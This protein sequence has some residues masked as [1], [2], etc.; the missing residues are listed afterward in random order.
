[1]DASGGVDTMNGVCFSSSGGTDGSGGSGGTGGSGSMECAGCGAG[2]SCGSGLVC[3]TA[4]GVSQCRKPCSSQAAC[5][6]QQCQAVTGITSGGACT[7]EAGGG[8]DTGDD[9]EYVTTTSCGCASGGPGLLASLLGLA[10]LVRR[11]RL[12]R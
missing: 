8:G 6:S 12:A 10:G 4:G 1:M 11:R 9:V 7:C 3:V 5:G 2:V